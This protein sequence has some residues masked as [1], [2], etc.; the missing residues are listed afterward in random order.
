MSRVL[1]NRGSCETSHDGVDKDLHSQSHLAL[2]LLAQSSVELACAI[3]FTAPMSGCS[4]E[5]AA[6]LFTGAEPYPAE[7]QPARQ[8]LVNEEFQLPQ[9]GDSQWANTHKST[10]TKTGLKAARPW[11]WAVLEANITTHLQAGPSR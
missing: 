2:L 10:E 6:P 8:S 5:P 3:P 11:G 7:M 1:L 4:R 9:L